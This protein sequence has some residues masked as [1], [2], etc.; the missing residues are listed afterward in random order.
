MARS[1][2]DGSATE[3]DSTHPGYEERLA[4]MTAHYDLL[5]RRPARALPGSRISLRYDR[6]DNLLV[7]T[8][9]PR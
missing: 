1:I 8:P 4:A 9:G 6:A 7:L 3:P 2:G 5:S